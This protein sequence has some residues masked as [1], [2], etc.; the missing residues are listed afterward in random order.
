MAG[1]ASAM[2]NF[3][4]N[5]VGTVGASLATLGWSSYVTGL[6]VICI[7]CAASSALIWIIIVKQRIMADRLFG[8]EKRSLKAVKGGD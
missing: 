6:A 2:V 1:A 3:I 7:G 5:I 8:R 4:L